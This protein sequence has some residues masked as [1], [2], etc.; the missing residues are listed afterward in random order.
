MK[1][2]VTDFDVS[3]MKEE[4]TA[5]DRAKNAFAMSWCAW[6]R[7]V[8]ALFA[9]AVLLVSYGCAHQEIIKVEGMKE[10]RL[11]DIVADAR[12][13]RVVFIGELH[14][15]KAHHEAQLS[16]IK[17]MKKAKIDFAIGFEMFNA[18]SQPELDKWTA[19]ES[20]REDIIEVYYL[21]WKIPWRQYRDIVYYAWENKIPVVGLNI[22]RDVIHQIVKS[23]LESL[24]PEQLKGFEDLSCD[25]DEA[26]QDVLLNAM[27]A[28]VGEVESASFKNFCEA[29]VYWDTAMANNVAAYLDANKDKSMVV[30][31]GGAHAWKRGIPRV[32]SAKTKYPYLV[33]MPEMPESVDRE[34]VNTGD[35]DYF[36][37][38]DP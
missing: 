3:V 17:A 6:R 26:Y 34:T 7:A 8:A 36:W 18:D 20:E 30:I 11:D 12:N 24:K 37:A 4:K 14:T 25:V 5:P 27:E 33:I 15:N 31:A 16:V 23:G 13:A 38:I 9:S 28:H 29:Q 21:N 10:A 22:K 1:R 2:A 32:L 35:A 19:G